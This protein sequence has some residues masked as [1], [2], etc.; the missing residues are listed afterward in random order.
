ML[1]EFPNI[2]DD[3]LMNHSPWVFA[4]EHRI[5]QILLNLQSNALKFTATGSVRV[6]V[7][8][9]GENDHFD[10]VVSVID[11]GVGISQAN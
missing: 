4:D 6:K 11:T 2:G 5:M 9:E 1:T 7:A 3:N 8:I 10:L